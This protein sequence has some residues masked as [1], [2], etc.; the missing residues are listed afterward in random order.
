[1]LNR[2]TCLQIGA[3]SLLGMNADALTVPAVQNDKS[4]VLVFLA[5][6]PTH[7]ETFN[8]I[9]NA[10]TEFRS[11]IDSLQ[12][13]DSDIMMGGLWDNLIKHTDKINVVNSFAHRNNS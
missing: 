6:G 5:G 13:K 9:P 8:P 12:A 3:L 10:P 7:V 1:M 11:I 4:V 2:R